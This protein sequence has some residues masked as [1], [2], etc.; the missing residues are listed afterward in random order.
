MK[1]EVLMA[2]KV[3]IMSFEDVR[4]YIVVRM[5]RV[6]KCIEVEWREGYGEMWM[7]QFMTLC[8]SLLLLFSV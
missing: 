3:K 7:L 5:W 8:I 1:F 4:W 2:M 6:R